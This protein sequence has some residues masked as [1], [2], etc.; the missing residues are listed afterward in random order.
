MSKFNF[1]HFF[2]KRVKGFGVWFPTWKIKWLKMKTFKDFNEDF[3][4]MEKIREV[5]KKIACAKNR[6]KNTEK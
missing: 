5:P 2:W 1:G 3:T 4:L 6:D